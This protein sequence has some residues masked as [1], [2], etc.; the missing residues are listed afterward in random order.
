LKNIPDEEQHGVR[1]LIKKTNDG[2]FGFVF[3]VDDETVSSVEINVDKRRSREK[4]ILDWNLEK[5]LVTRVWPLPHSLPEVEVLE[6]SLQEVRSLCL[7]LLQEVFCMLILCKGEGM[8]DDLYQAI[9]LLLVK[10]GILP[11]SFSV[12]QHLPSDLSSDS[13]LLFCR[14]LDSRSF[15]ESNLLRLAQPEPRKRNTKA[16]ISSSLPKIRKIEQKPDEQ[17]SQ[18]AEGNANTMTL[19]LDDA[20]KMSA[21]DAA[22]MMA[23]IAAKRQKLFLQLN[24]L[25]RQEITVMEATLARAKAAE[26]ELL[27]AINDIDKHEMPAALS[28]IAA[29]AM[30][31][32]AEPQH[33]EA[34][35]PPAEP[36]A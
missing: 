19:V 9:Q 17:S 14:D 35:A 33:A 15:C 28:A 6:V 22:A 3:D 12:E 18:E 30:A 1:I 4:I 29:A 26:Q 31:P 13:L 16:S 34:E 23:E 24:N 20:A 2:G 7:I 36:E 5:E 11:Q 32:P 25:R 10:P 27:Q 21:E 8:K